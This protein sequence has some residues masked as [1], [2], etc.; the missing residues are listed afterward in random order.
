MA[1][2]TPAPNGAPARPGGTLR[3]FLR[4]SITLLV[5]IPLLAAAFLFVVQ[6]RMIYFP[7]P[8]DNRMGEMLRGTRARAIEFRS[9]GDVQVCY[10]VPAVQGSPD[11]PIWFLFGGN[12]SRAFDWIDTVEVMQSAHPD[13]SFVLVEYPGYG[14]SG[15]DPGRNAILRLSGDLRAE[16][17]RLTGLSSEQLARR[18]CILGHS[19]GVAAGLEF[20][21]SHGARTVVAISPFTDLLSMARRSVGPVYAHLLRDRWDNRAA[22]AS[23]GSL[24]ERPRVLLFHG[25]DDRIVPVAM[26]RELAG[27]HRGWIE[28]TELPSLDHN[29]I[30]EP[31]VDRMLAAWDRPSATGEGDRGGAPAG[32]TGGNP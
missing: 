10:W 4:V 7:R 11:A 16:V 22:L 13:W 32:G 5:S 15:G 14:H 12:A 8:Y 25:S 28:Y 9:G 26:S 17:R 30:I 1:E 21:A 24:A 3:S 19:I 27:G 29:D 18:T 31:A 20:A 23:L 2:P 6:D